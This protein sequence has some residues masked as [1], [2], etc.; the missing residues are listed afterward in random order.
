MNPRQHRR[1]VIDDHT[2]EVYMCRSVAL[3][4][5]SFMLTVGRPPVTCP[6]CGLPVSVRAELLLHCAVIA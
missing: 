2:V 5:R 4:E 6:Q 3:K 1:L